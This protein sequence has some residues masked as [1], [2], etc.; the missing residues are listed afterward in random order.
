MQ[1]IYERKVTVLNG[2]G[3][4]R[5]RRTKYWRISCSQILAKSL[6]NEYL[7]SVGYDDILERY[8]VLHTNY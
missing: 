6:T 2:G 8:K 1:Q 5:R 4:A 3:L 7:V